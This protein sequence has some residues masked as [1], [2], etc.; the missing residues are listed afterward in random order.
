MPF[1]CCQDE[2]A[3]TRRSPVMELGFYKHSTAISGSWLSRHW[4][5]SMA[6]RGIEGYVQRV[7]TDHVGISPLVGDLFLC[8][9][10]E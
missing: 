9:S 6:G 7:R 2:V 4:A 8:V 10:Q 5:C 3:R 1:G